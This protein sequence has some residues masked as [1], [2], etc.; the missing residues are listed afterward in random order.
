MHQNDISMQNWYKIINDIFDILY[1]YQGFEIQSV[2]YKAFQ[3]S[4][5][6]SAQQH[7]WSVA[8]VPG[9]AGIH[10]HPESNQVPKRDDL[11]LE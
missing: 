7:I 2:S 11:E 3:L 9:R 8:T 10:R 6:S 5:I 1:S 4:C